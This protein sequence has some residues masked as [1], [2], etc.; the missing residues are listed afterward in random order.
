MEEFSTQELLKIAKLSA[1]ELNDEE[2]KT[3]AQK[4]KQTLT[5]VEELDKV[6]TSI[7]HE[8]TKNINV[9]RDDKVVQTNT[10]SILQQ[11]PQTK[12]N[13]FV[14]PKILD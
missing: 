12:D 14:V 9:F 3:L 4:L 10:A 2:I 5:Y 1:L 6:K 11:A 8:A 7:E 13:H